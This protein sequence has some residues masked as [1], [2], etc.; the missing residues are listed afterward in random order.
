VCES[1][2][3][4]SPI[5]IHAL[6]D[7]HVVAT[8][9]R[10]LIQIWRGV[11]TG[12]ASANVNKIANVFVAADPFP[13]TSL[14]VV[15]PR[16]P[17]PDDE[18]RRNFATFSRDIVS[19]MS[20][21]VIVSEGGGFRGALVRAVGVALTTMVPHRS[22]FKFVNDLETAALL[23]K[24]HLLPRTGGA[25]ELVRTAELLRARIGSQKFGT[26]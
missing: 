15:E 10:T 5:D 18:T 19:K 7:A 3:V 11:P 14:F 26:K 1:R 20:L 25:E 9:G 21:A 12:K 2:G 8:W 6:D 24:P 13:A 4:P 17:S 16:S 23:L 22:H